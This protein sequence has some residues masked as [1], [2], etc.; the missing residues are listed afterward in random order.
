MLEE[1]GQVIA[2]EQGAV[3]VRVAR[4]SACGSCQARA[5]CGQGIA[6]VIRSESCHEVRA[7]TDLQ[8]QEGDFVVLG[9]NEELALRSALLVYLMPMLALITGAV[10][11]QQL[12]L[13]EGWSIILAALAFSGSGL[14]LYNHNKR[15]ADNI[16][17]MPIVLRAELAVQS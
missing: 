4:Q 3:R 14:Y 5:V 15:N 10:V 6:Q 11:G 7:L 1:R 12:G 16:K 8:L 2:V 9:V 13:A 17:F